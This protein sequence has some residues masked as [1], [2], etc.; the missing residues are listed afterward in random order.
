MEKLIWTKTTPTQVGWYWKREPL[1]KFNGTPEIVFVRSYAGE[2]SI[3]NNNLKGWE[4][5]EKWDW[6]GPIPMP[7]EK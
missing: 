3:G 4:S 7:I 6:A 1:S 2:L 5:V